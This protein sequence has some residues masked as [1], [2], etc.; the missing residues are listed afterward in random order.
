[1]VHDYKLTAQNLEINSATNIVGPYL[2]TKLL[3]ETG[4]LQKGSRVVFVTSGGMYTSKLRPSIAEIQAV[5][6][7]MRGSRFSGLNQY[8]RNKRQ[9]VVLTEVLA[10]TSQNTGVEYYSWHPGW[11]DTKALRESMPTFR[12]AS[13]LIIRDPVESAYGLID[14][15]SAP[16]SE[17]TPGGC[18]FD[19]RQTFKHIP[20]TGTEHREC[21]V[22]E[23]MRSLE[24]L[25]KR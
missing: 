18:Y 3:L 19:G 20:C 5:D 12:K 2:M 10:R 23:L 14:L 25:S 6:P 7:E 24:A 17:L 8:A 22:Q 9:Q 4:S 21:D 16:S 13:Y 1:M 11:A 15:L